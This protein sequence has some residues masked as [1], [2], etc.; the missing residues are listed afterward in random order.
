MRTETEAAPRNGGANLINAVHGGPEEPQPPHP[1][2]QRRILW[3]CV[4]GWTAFVGLA[5]WWLVK[6]NG[7]L[8]VWVF[9]ERDLNQPGFTDK[10]QAIF[11]F[12][13]GLQRAYPWILFGPFLALVVW[14]FPLERER[15][16]RNLP[17]NAA[18][19]LA[20]AWA[21]HAL[22]LRTA[23]TRPNLVMVNSDYAPAPGT[24]P[25]GKNGFVP[26]RGRR[27]EGRPGGSDGPIQYMGPVPGDFKRP[28]SR[29]AL[30]RSTIVDLL[31]YGAVTGLVHSV[32][33][34]RRLRERERR[35]LLL[36]S[37]LANARLNTLKAQLQPH[38]LFNSLNAIA[39]LLRRDPRL[40]E[41]TLVAL[42]ELLRLALS[43]SER[44]EGALREELEFVQRYLEI[45]QTRFGD[46]LRVE[47]D[48]D[49]Q[50]LDCLVP[51]LV[52]Q[53]LVE[54][55][56]RHGIEPAEKAGVVRVS[57][58][59]KDGKLV[60]SVE[61]DGVG[62]ASGNPDSGGPHNPA[63]LYPRLPAPAPSSATNLVLARAGTGIGLANLRERLQALYG[64]RQKLELTPRAT[65]G[66]IVRVEIPWRSRGES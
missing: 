26:L 7:G 2:R 18:A 57:A 66:V 6:G 41:T 32:N 8:S 62:L 40:A 5:L 37:N 30:L 13:L 54:N 4:L 12:D 33:F 3:I 58:S 47:Q 46:K 64:A 63:G 52:L 11:R 31:A 39:T 9:Q 19:C 61:D 44:Q 56:I 27:S 36:E 22:D 53:P 24:P 28:P 59:R 49:P 65:G 34:Y 48:I 14:Y 35:A 10:V 60:L 29:K 17:L 23:L 43:Q 20:F 1:L 38:F 16:R 50:A 15:L 42:S 21:C 25:P 55:A 45:Q 51:T